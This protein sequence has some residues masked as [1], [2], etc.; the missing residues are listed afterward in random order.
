MLDSPSYRRGDLKK[1]SKKHQ[2]ETE[3]SSLLS[4]SSSSPSSKPTVAGLRAGA[5]APTSAG[6][7]E[8]RSAVCIFSRKRGSRGAEGRGE[9]EEEGRLGK[10]GKC[11]SRGSS[12]NRKFPLFFFHTFVKFL[13]FFYL[14]PEDSFPSRSQTTRNGA[15]LPLPLGAPDAPG[16]SHGEN[17]GIGEVKRVAVARGEMRD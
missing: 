16:R 3:M 1:E 11:F 14:F 2:L 4:L 6:E 5:R 13:P 7:A 15:S 9:K 10:E 12:E 17:W 8:M